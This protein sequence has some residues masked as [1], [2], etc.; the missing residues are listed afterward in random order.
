MAENKKETEQSAESKLPGEKKNF[1]ST[2]TKIN[3]T[4][5]KRNRAISR[6]RSPGERPYSVVKRTFHN[7]RTN[8]KT[9]ERV[10][11]KEMFKCFAYN[12]YQLVTLERKRLLVIEQ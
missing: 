5:K 9:L 7:D 11:V 12:L 10:M 4:P 8:V 3:T 2:N 6:I 1:F